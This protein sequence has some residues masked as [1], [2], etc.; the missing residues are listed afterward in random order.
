[1]VCS[2]SMGAAGVFVQR[3]GRVMSSS[4]RKWAALGKRSYQHVATRAGGS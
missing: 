4:S 3:G 2:Q 1:M